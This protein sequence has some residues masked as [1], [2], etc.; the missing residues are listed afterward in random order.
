M[1]TCT[2][3]VSGLG[4]RLFYVIDSGG[5][6]DK[7]RLEWDLILDYKESEEKR[8][9]RYVFRRSN[10]SASSPLLQVFTL[11]SNFSRKLAIWGG[12]D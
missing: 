2:L 4:T 3:T 7:I 1:S 12:G 6:K 10:V 9:G 11:V 5:M 8:Q